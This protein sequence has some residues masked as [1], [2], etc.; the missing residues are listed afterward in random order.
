MRPAPIDV[1]RSRSKSPT[2]AFRSSTPKSGRS[3]SSHILKPRKREKILTPS[4]MLVEP[5][6]PPG[7]PP[8]IRRVIKRPI[9]KAISKNDSIVSLC[10]ITIKPM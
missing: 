4:G 6:T 8:Y 2:A 9:I 5:R 10:R 1:S 3:I 7:P